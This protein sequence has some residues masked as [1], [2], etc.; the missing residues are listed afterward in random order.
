MTGTA[1]SICPRPLPTRKKRIQHVASKIQRLQPREQSVELF[2]QHAPD[3]VAV[4]PVPAPSSDHVECQSVR[5]EHTSRY[6][7]ETKPSL[8]LVQPGLYWAARNFLEATLYAPDAR[9]G[10]WRESRYV[11]FG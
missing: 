11:A 3:A 2:A 6:E 5:L 7:V 10:V 4:H 8:Q 9:I 1:E